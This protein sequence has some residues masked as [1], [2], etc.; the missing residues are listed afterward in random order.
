MILNERHLILAAK[1]KVTREIAEYICGDESS[2]DIHI[3][4]KKLGLEKSTVSGI[5]YGTGDYYGKKFADIPRYHKRKRRKMS[6]EI[7]KQVIADG[8][9]LKEIA[10]DTGRKWNT[11]YQARRRYFKKLNS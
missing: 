6:D 4:A 3:V 7:F 9:N 2:E 10:R 5:R 11:L 8:A 1:T